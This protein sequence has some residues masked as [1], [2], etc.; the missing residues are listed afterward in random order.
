MPSGV[1]IRTEECKKNL[2]KSHKGQIP[3]IKGKHLSEEYKKKISLACKGRISPNKGKYMP[4]EQKIKLSIINKGKHPKTE[5][6]KGCVPWNMG[7][8]EIYSEE[9]RR[10]MSEA[11]K[12]YIPWIKGK[13]HTIDSR[14]AIGI[15]HKGKIPWN[16]GKHMSEEQKRKLS[17][18]RKGIIPW[19]KGKKG[20]MCGEKHYNW[21]GGISFEPY[22]I[23]WTKTLKRAIRERDRYICQIC[24]A[25]GIIVHHINYIKTDCDPNNLI[26]L[27]NR[28]HCKT[29]H[30]REKWI[31]YF[32]NRGINN[33]HMVQN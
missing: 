21:R 26:T 2:S 18:S 10:K 7:K 16:K 6:K 3:W 23:Y 12:G 17:I 5:F 31:E 30:N 24:F 27:C 28:C 32:K 19:N 25:E 29:N 33:A 22:P 15:V 9:T 11:K 8:K 13:H 20:V 14:T 4:M 1:Y